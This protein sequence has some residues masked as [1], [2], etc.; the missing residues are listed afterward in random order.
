[1]QNM[2][3]PLFCSLSKS[4]MWT[5]Y[6]FVDV[7]DYAFEPRDVQIRNGQWVDDEF[8]ILDFLGRYVDHYY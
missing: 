3:A 1:M 5:K 6:Q 4:L 8:A 7:D 2:T